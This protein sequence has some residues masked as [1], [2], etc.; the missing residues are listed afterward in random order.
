LRPVIVRVTIAMMKH[1]D[2]THWERNGFFWL[3]LHPRKSG[4][5]LK[6]GK[7]PEAGAA[8]K[9]MMGYSFLA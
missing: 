6:Q 8:T 7:N 1:N 2:Q 9:A 4:Q 3:T 5:E